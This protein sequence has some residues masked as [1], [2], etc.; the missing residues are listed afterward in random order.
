MKNSIGLL[1]CVLFLISCK[2]NNTEV[3]NQKNSCANQAV[4]GDTTFCLPQKKGFTE[5]YKNEKIKKVLAP[6]DNEQSKTLAYYIPTP[7]FSALIKNRDTVYDNYYKIYVPKI[8]LNYSITPF[9][10][11]EVLNN[12][13][14]GMR[15]VTTDELDEKLQKPEFLSSSA[16]LLLERYTKNKTQYTVIALMEDTSNPNIKANAVSIT[17]VLVKDRLVLVAHY[18]DY[19]NQQTISQLKENNSNFIENFITTNIEK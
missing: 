13:A 9:E 14:N 16:P 17:G 6:F 5:A 11:N 10:M 7:V 8:A 3:N 4:F 18:L 12:M 15:A 2:H 1:I 19:Y